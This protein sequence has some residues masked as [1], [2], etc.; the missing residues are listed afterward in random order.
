MGWKSKPSVFRMPCTDEQEAAKVAEW[1]RS[2]R[3]IDVTGVEGREVL[4][5]SSTP[6]F[7]FQVQ[8][9]ALLN[10]FG[11]GHEAWL[12]A[13]RYEDAMGWKPGRLSKAAIQKQECNQGD[14]NARL[15]REEAEAHEAWKRGGVL[16][17]LI[18][19]ALREMDR[20]DLLG[21]NVDGAC[22]AQEPDVELWKAGLRYPQWEQLL[23]LAELTHRSPL[24]FTQANHALRRKGGDRAFDTQA[25]KQVVGQ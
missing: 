9:A 23:R 8:E 7:A 18:T 22:G 21:I 11:V 1:L 2:E 3:K 19:A 13:F 4:I 20:H 17:Y 16:P 14:R 25:I 6:G 12:A 5:P 15:A 10:D 24:F